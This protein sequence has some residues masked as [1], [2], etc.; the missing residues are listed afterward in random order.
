M[1]GYSRL[2]EDNEWTLQRMMNHIEQG[3]IPTI[4]GSHPEYMKDAN[5]NMRAM[6]DLANQL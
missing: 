4:S 1:I 3:C 5:K 6:F 2:E